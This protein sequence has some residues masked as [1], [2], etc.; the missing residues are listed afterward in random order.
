MTGGP[1]LAL[2]APANNLGLNCFCWSHTVCCTAERRLHNHGRVGVHQGAEAEGRQAQAG[3]G[4]RRSRSSRRS[5][6]A[7]LL[8]L[9]GGIV[10]I[11]HL[12]DDDASYRII[13]GS[14]LTQVYVHRSGHCGNP[15]RGREAR[16][17]HQRVV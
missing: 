7:Q 15:S 13:D 16:V 8:P 12:T 6:Q 2:H 11:T 10:I 5:A 14:N 3:D 9:P 1:A 17:P 4:V